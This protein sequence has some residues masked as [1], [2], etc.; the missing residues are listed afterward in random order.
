MEKY[1]PENERVKHKYVGYLREAKGQGEDSLDAVLKALSR[2]EAYTRY[3]SFKA[4]RT[5]QATH[6][7]HLGHEDVL[8]TFTSYGAV[9]PHRQAE[10]MRESWSW[11]KQTVPMEDLLRQLVEELREKSVPR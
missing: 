1:D 10:I 4:F 7:K 8:T 5:E 9:A 2:F 11:Q 3:R 6:F